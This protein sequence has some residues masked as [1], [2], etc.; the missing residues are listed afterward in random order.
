MF[1]D[2]INV[3]LNHKKYIIGHKITLAD[4]VL[5]CHLVSYYRFYLDVKK[6]S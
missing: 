5:T 4:I 2:D 1:L 3:E 6:R